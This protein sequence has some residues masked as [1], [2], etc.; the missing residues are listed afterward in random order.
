MK[1]V[2]HRESKT[3][4]QQ[5]ELKGTYFVADKNKQEE[6]ERLII[7]DRMVTAAMGGVL[8]EQSE[9]ASLQLVL[10]VG[11]GSGG[12][13]LEAARLYP[14]LSLV[15]VDISPLMIEYAN[16][17]AQEQQL[18]DRVKFLVMDALVMLEFPT[19]HFDLVNLRF[20]SSFLRTW[21]WPKLINEMLRITRPNGVVRITDSMI[22][23]ENT[24]EALQRFFKILIHVG[25]QT[26]HSYAEDP[27]GMTNHLERL[28]RLHGC[29]NIQTKEHTVEYEAGT[30]EM[31]LYIAD[32]T[33]V[34]QTIRPFIQKF[35]DKSDYDELDAIRKQALVEMQQPGFHATWK[36]LTAWGRRPQKIPGID[37][38][39]LRR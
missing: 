39:A 20:G 21:D 15:G 30:P 33:R 6:L 35:G 27:A 14:S 1:S 38:G 34:I 19:A 16:A 22:G 28:M 11:C 13:A 10:D 7:Q 17:Q 9:P 5:S 8:A 36:L 2:E 26:G 3:R 24:S 12:W 29:L 32:T 31:E 18:S 37:G 25:Y 23:N 4:Q